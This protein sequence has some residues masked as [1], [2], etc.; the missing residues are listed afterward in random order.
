M[1]SE[2]VLTDT[3]FFLDDLDQKLFPGT[4]S[5]PQVHNGFGEAHAETAQTILDE[6]KRLISTKGAN[7][8]LLVSNFFIFT[9][10]SM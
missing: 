3:D 1:H 2:S 6:T 4:G 8:V 10:D 9:D 7:Q 5:A